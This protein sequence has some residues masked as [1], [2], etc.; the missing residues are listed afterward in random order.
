MSGLISGCRD[1]D[2]GA[3]TF[4]GH[5]DL[6]ALLQPA[7]LAAVAC[8]LV[9]LAIL[10]SVAGVHHVLLDTAAEEALKHREGKGKSRKGERG[11]ETVRYGQTSA[12]HFSVS[13][14]FHFFGAQSLNSAS[15]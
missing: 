1:S 8:D 10:V 12:E 6:K 14:L 4:L 3:L 11:R 15:S 7:V 9:N 13:L 5:A 2:P